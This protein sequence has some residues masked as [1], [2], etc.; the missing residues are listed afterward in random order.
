MTSI[1]CKIFEIFLRNALYNHLV[2]N[3][4]LSNDQFGFCSGRSCV[5]QLLVTLSSWMEST[6]NSTPVDAIYLDFS[7]AFDTVPH[8]IFMSKLKSYITG[9]VF[10]WIQN[11]LTNREQYVSINDT[12]SSKLNVTSGVPQGSVLGPTLFI[13]YINDLPEVTS[14]NIKIFADDTKVF[15]EI[16]SISD[17]N[18][19]QKSIDDMFMWTKKWL[20]QFNKS[21]CKVLHLGKNN[22]QHDYFIGDV[23]Q[24]KLLK[25]QS[26]KDLGVYID[27]LLNFN[28]HIS[29]VTKKA[30]R[31][32]NLIMR[33]ITLKNIDIMLPLYKTLIRPIIEYGNCV[34][35]P[36]KR[37][38]IDMIE[39]VQRNFTKCIKGLKNYEYKER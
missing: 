22:P 21:K 28:S 6:D 37:K 18:D 4:L 9:N 13:Y 36:Y 5:T 24:I 14:M 25:T 33:T 26:E 38:D 12:I 23:N 1:V 16:K 3:N 8:K 39:S 11:F 32:A 27:P 19:L 29:E 20:L 15:N 34:W 30:R 10:N 31:M 17:C 7:K 35:Y 2:E